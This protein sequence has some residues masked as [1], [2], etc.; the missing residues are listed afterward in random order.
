[1]KNNKYS[2]TAHIFS[3]TLLIF[4]FALFFVSASYA[5]S[6]DYDFNKDVSSNV[7]LVQNDFTLNNSIYG[8]AF[9]IG[10]QIKINGLVEK[11]LAA[12]TS[13]FVL[14]GTA[15]DDLRVFANDVKISG[16]VFSEAMLFA[17]NVELTNSSVFGGPVSIYAS[18]VKI[19]GLIKDDI[20]ISADRIV[21]NGVI[22]KNAEFD[23]SEIIF[24]PDA[25]IAGNLLSNK[26]NMNS[27]NVYGSVS[28]LKKEKNDV[29][30]SKLIYFLMVFVVCLVIVSV[31]R[32]FSD[33]AI[34]AVQRRSFLA[35]ISGFSLLI[36]LPLVALFLLVT[37][38]G[39][40]L[41]I[42]LFVVYALILI[43]GG[44]YGVI[45]VGRGI[46]SLINNKSKSL[47]LGVFFGALILTL[48]SFIPSV[49][50]LVVF[51]LIVFGIGGFALA[52]LNKH[53][54]KK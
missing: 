49:F 36:G 1:M 7:Y 19:D 46:L 15:G 43:V 50:G 48:I 41:A 4:L 40:P 53:K 16:Y 33:K 51:I 18:N 6:G 34:D 3:K 9:I 54:K 37:I 39:I 30:I 8:D 38:I 26:K 2:K 13:N 20:K 14:N 52:I 12:F 17:S 32:R 24:G 35:F 23:A 47:I 11:D 21:F 22:E 42:L 27:S 25:K 29:F 45:Y 5:F 10:D 31:G 44:A 28:E